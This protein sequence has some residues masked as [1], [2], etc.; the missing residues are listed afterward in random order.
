MGESEILAAMLCEP[1][2][3]GAVVAS[4]EPRDFAE[5]ANRKLYQTI[6]S[7]NKEGLRPDSTLLVEKGISL[8]RIMELEADFLSTANL[9]HY[10]QTLKKERIMRQ[11]E[12]AIEKDQDPH[13]LF[14]FLQVEMRNLNPPK[15]DSFQ[16]LL[17]QA[18]KQMSDGG[19]RGIGTGIPLL[20]RCTNGLQQGHFWVIASRPAIGKTA[21]AVNLA[22]HIRKDHKVSF[23]SLEMTALSIAQRILCLQS[24]IP[25]SRL[26]RGKI[27]DDEK[28]KLNNAQETL[29]SGGVFIHSGDNRL[30]TIKDQVRRDVEEGAEIVIIDYLNLI[31]GGRGT[32][33][34]E[35]VGEITR[36]IKMMSLEKKIPVLGLAQLG[37]AAE[38]EKPTLSDLRESGS[39]EQDA[40]LVGLLMRERGSDEAVLD[41][42]KNRHGAPRKINLNFNAELMVFTER[43]I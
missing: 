13:D 18:M 42:A 8:S 22:T 11:V 25:F 26:V 34:W 4:I 31:S 28:V 16:D 30:A 33:R 36:E 7:I 27:S 21:L 41:I 43:G 40:D 12:L 14:D 19:T 35:I 38:K 24:S 9:D 20:N 6:L 15:E 10:C 37:R 39:I 23:F 5:P 3:I 2:C 32:Q 1:K 17:G 29:K